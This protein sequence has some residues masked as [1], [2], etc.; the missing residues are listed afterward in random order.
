MSQADTHVSWVVGR[1]RTLGPAPFF[2]VGIVNVTPDSFYDGGQSAGTDQAVTRG[3][4]LLDQGADILDIGGE[5]TRPFAEPVSE[6]EELHRVLPVIKC[7]LQAAPQAIISVDTTKSAV[8]AACLDAGALIVN[9]VSA[10]TQDPTLLDV[11]V[12]RQAGYVLMHSQGS[13]RTMQVAPHYDD[14][15]EDMHRFFSSRLEA[16]LQAGIS[17]QRIVIDPG[18]GFGKTLRHNV[19]ILKNVDTFLQF[20]RPIFMGLSNK[21][22]WKTL[23]GRDGQERNA[24]TLAATTWLYTRGVRIHRVHEVRETRDAL[25]VVQTLH[26]QGEVWC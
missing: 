3:L 24:A 19:E 13:P 17:E 4:A 7:L 22:M 20:N 9:D 12:S 14:I 8:A 18:I 21:S 10:L 16:L 6:A 1:G 5:S 25:T 26:G 2:V 23:L 15:L 11:V